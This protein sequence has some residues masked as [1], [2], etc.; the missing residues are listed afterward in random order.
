[1][2]KMKQ[3]S[4]SERK[5]FMYAYLNGYFNV[6]KKIN[7]PDIAKKFG[8]STAYVCICIR[9]GTI[10]YLDMIFKSYE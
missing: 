7:M 10:F 5:I 3:L 6:P 4:K 8:I 1:M 9:K 2:I